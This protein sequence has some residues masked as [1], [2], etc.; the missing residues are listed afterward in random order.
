[1]SFSRFMASVTQS[2]STIFHRN[3]TT[4][5]RP[6]IEMRAGVSRPTP[7]CFLAGGWFG[8][9]I[10]LL[11]RKGKALPEENRPT[12]IFKFFYSNI[13]IAFVVIT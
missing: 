7:I 13:F 12:P 1:M 4:T 2:Q 8:P 6:F 11:R 5:S 10:L 3:N 9:E